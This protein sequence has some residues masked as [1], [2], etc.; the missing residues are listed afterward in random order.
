MPINDYT[1]KNLTNNQIWFSS[2]LD[3]ND[4]FDY[5]VPH[6]LN[7]T[8]D[9]FRK[10]IYRPP[11]IPEEQYNQM[12]QYCK[13][14][15]K[16][17]EKWIENGQS[18]FTSKNRVACFC[19][20][21]T[22]ILMWSHYAA[23]HEGLCLKFDS[24]YDNRFFHEDDWNY[25]KMPIKKVI[26]PKKIKKINYFKDNNNFFFNCAYTKSHQWYYEKEHRIISA[27]D[28]I[29][30]NKK[31]LVEINFGCKLNQEDSKV[32][33]IIKLVK[34]CKYPNVKFIQANKCKDRFELE[35][36]EIQ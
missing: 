14:N 33:D 4:P 18:N 36:E 8:D 24:S 26:Y 34:S 29:K 11:N 12:L 21:K 10:I 23:S 17:F 1:I 30:F 15:P 7:F 16:E 31:S 35:F 27:V 19:E 32:Q 25:H 9:E 20:E 6:N 5:F 13:E 28:S 3:F 2:P 22:N